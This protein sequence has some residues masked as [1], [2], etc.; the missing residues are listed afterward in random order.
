MELFLFPLVLFVLLI[1]L[2]WF[3]EIQDRRQRAH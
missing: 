3:R 2:L 1:T